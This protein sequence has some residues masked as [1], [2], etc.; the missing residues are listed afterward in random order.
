[1]VDNNNDEYQF[2]DMDVISPDP[3]AEED[4]LGE[5]T[6]TIPETPPSE[7]SNNKIL[8]NSI[9]VVILVIV[10]ML[11]YSFISSFSSKKTSDIVNVPT[12]QNTPAVSDTSK[13]TPPIEQQPVVQQP[14][15]SAGPDI[16]ALTQRITTLENTQQSMSTDINN[17]N[18][19]LNGINQNINNLN[20]KMADLSQIITNLTNKVDQQADQIAKL[21]VV[22]PPR[23]ISSVSKR[24]TEPQIY[25][26]QAVIPGRAW[27]IASNGSTLT[28]RE[29]TKIKGYGIIKLID[30]NQGR[31]LTTSGRIIRFSQQDS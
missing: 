22:H 20:S 3:I 8:R 9:F 13:V 6:Y 11:L 26:I 5:K 24:R 16:S 7:K 1:M 2:A 23:R 18:N 28:V 21:L 27:L 12:L 10:A 29:G 30:P 19:Q 31:I 17:L 25:Y 4:I 14:V 15:V